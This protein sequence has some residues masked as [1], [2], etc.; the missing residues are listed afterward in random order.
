MDDLAVMEI[1]FVS[2]VTCFFN[3]VLYVTGLGV[4]GTFTSGV[5]PDVNDSQ[6]TCNLTLN[7]NP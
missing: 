7:P 3:S 6:P 5:Y 2:E 1:T 4:W